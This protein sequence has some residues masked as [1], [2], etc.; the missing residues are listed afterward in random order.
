MSAVHTFAVMLFPMLNVVYLTSVLAT[1]R[2]QC[3]VW[4]FALVPWYCAFRCIAQVCC[5][6]S[7]DVVDGTATT[8]RAGRSGD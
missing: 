7:R 1:I 8:L 4:L 6:C 2:V 3:L 5:C